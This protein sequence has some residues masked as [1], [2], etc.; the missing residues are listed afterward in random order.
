MPIRFSPR[1]SRSIPNMLR[2]RPPNR[3]RASSGSTFNVSWPTATAIYRMP[4]AFSASIGGPCSENCPRTPCRSNP[5]DNLRPKGWV[6]AVLL[7]R[8][9]DLQ[10]T[11]DAVHL[12]SDLDR[13]HLLNLCRRRDFGIDADLGARESSQRAF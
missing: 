13:P 4:L 10:T 11:G 6:E 1:S 8:I 3:S 12:V 5:T 9:L 2:Y 7:F